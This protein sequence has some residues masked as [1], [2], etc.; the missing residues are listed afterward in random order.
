VGVNIDD[1]RWRALFEMA[2]TTF[3]ELADT[4]G[5][6]RWSEPGL[7]VWSVRDLVGHTSR[8]LLT[9]ELYLARDTGTIALDSPVAYL[10]AAGAA[11]GTAAGNEAI[12]QRGRDAGAALGPEPA[13]A[14]QQLAERV[15]SLVDRT[16]GDA[17]CST[18]AGGITL[19]AY[20][21]TRVYELTVH[22][23]DLAA[24]LG[25]DVPDT[26][27]EPVAA[28]LDLLAAT[29]G[30]TPSAVDVLLALAG[31]RSLPEPFHVI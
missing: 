25:E 7:G 13:A 3:T 12:A 22:S 21:P 17:P 18:P 14:V 9:I 10:L 11:T 24:A 5:P 29:I 1:D 19:A 15:S 6:D 27:D 4:I 23:L 8:A 16:A 28:C 30:A 26:F 31:R 2:T 20:L